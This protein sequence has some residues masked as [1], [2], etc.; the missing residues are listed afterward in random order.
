MFAS[1]LGHVE[2]VSQL[3]DYGVDLSIQTVQ[4]QTALSLAKELG[5]SETARV[6]EERLQLIAEHRSQLE[7]MQR[8]QQEEADRAAANAAAAGTILLCAFLTVRLRRIG[9]HRFPST[10]SQ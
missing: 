5:Q 2:I 8:Q 10:L 3:L 6:L 7:A 1:S 9:W 4:G